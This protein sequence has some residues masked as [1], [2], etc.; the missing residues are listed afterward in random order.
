MFELMKSKTK[1]VQCTLFER[2]DQLVL[3]LNSEKMIPEDAP[4]RLLSAQL[5]ELDY[6]KLYSAYSSYGRKSA[7]DPRVLFKVLVYGYQSGIY[8]SRKLEEAC[9]YRIDFMWLLGE[10][11]APDHTTFARF[12]SGRCKDALEDLFYQFVRRLES[13]G[14]TDHSAVF[15]DPSRTIQLRLAKKRGEISVPDQGSSER[16]DRT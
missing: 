12:R 7:A 14:E 5:E 6:T 13:M 15:I 2:H 10:R 9:Q 3:A 4:V 1:Q 8:S 16:K 11:K